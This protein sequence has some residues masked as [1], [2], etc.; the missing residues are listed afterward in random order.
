MVEIPPPLDRYRFIPDLPLYAQELRR[1]FPHYV[2]LNTL[3]GEAGAIQRLL[4]R[5]GFRVEEVEGL[6]LFRRIQGEGNIGDSRAFLLGL[7]YPQSITSAMP[8]EA[9]APRPGE[10]IL[11]LCASPGGKTTHMAQV[12]GDRG[13]V[14]A[15]DR[16]MDR[17]TALSANV[18]R[19]GLTSVV[20]TFHR[21]ESFPLPRS[22]QQGFHGVVVDAPCSGQGRYKVDGEGR[23]LYR[24][25]GR[26]N[27]SAIQ[28]GLLVRGYD[29]LRPGGRL[30]YSTCTLDPLENEAVVDY[31]LRKRPARVEA[32]EPPLR[33]SPGVEGFQGLR[34][35]PQ[36]RECRRFYP[37]HVRATGFFVALISKPG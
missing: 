19:M 34:F 32:W 22:P 9:L 5:E 28:K 33:W 37:H 1:P 2:R 35:H 3:K 18:K 10:T 16:R 36:I 29:L 12:M 20:V 25:E 7:I 4:E 13:V 24:V 30:V 31:L 27:L 26:T 17:L 23:L 8:V 14:V 6:P 21:G 11:D 15:N